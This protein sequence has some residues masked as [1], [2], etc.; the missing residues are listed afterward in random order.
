MKAYEHFQD[1]LTFAQEANDSEHFETAVVSALMALTEA[2]QAMVLLQALEENQNP[3]YSD[4]W[5][6]IWQHSQSVRQPEA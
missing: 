5:R 1:S 3:H 4:E 6:L 2:V